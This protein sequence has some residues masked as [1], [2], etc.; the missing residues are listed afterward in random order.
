MFK[1]TIKKKRYA[2]VAQLVERDLAKVEAAGSSPVSRSGKS[3]RPIRKYRSFCFPEQETDDDK[4]ARQPPRKNVASRCIWR[5]LERNAHAFRLFDCPVDARGLWSYLHG[6]TQIFILIFCIQVVYSLFCRQI[7]D[8]R[9]VF[10]GRKMWY[11]LR[12][13]DTDIDLWRGKCF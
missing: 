6:D 9:F 2:R 5:R 8:D 3:E 13:S 11:Y 1:R 12:R 7:F 4:A 10:R